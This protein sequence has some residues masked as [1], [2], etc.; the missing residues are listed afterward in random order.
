V[1]LDLESQAGHVIR[2]LSTG[3]ITIGTDVF[4]SPVIVSAE[5]IIADW[6]PPPVHALTLADFDRLLELDPEVILVGTG[7][8]QRFLSAALMAAI[9]DRGIGI[10]V[11]TTA[12]ACRTYNVLA[13]E[14][15]R[16]VAAL[17]IS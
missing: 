3:E 15:R 9:L 13:S 14:Y 1:K 10:E 7:A 17:F 6:S 12:A 5:R 8:E 11:M 2:G 16:V 4:R